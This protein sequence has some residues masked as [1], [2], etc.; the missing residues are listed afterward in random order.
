MCVEIRRS[1][2][3]KLLPR[4]EDKKAEIEGDEN[5]TSQND[6]INETPQKLLNIHDF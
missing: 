1:R 5:K 3:I 2:R 6:G 4:I